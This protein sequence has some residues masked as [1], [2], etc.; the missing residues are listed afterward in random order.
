M[1]LDELLKKDLFLLELFKEISLKK[2]N[3]EDTDITA[4]Y[5]ELFEGYSLNN[6]IESLKR[7]I[8]IQWYSVT[9]PIQNTGIGDLNIE[10][11]KKNLFNV[12]QLILN[13]TIDIEFIE[14]L[15]HYY[16]I[17]DWYFDSF[18]N[19]QL[20]I[21]ITNHTITNIK[22]AENRGIMSVYWDSI[23]NK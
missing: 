17:S 2:I 4:L 22:V 3:L 11:Q 8:F 14:M 5:D 15:N 1:K 19:L 9:E 20:L 16:N 21:P 6:E 23:L 12:N 18:S 7:A 13:K 10:L